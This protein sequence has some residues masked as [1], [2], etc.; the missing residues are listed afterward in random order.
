LRHHQLLHSLSLTHCGGGSTH[1][2]TLT[3]SLTWAGGGGGRAPAGLMEPKGVV[4]VGGV[5][6]GNGNP[7]AYGAMLVC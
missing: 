6:D 5:D 2:G 3:H 7:P 1:T 4:V